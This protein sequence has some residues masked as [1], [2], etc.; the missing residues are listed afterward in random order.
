[1]RLRMLKMRVLRDSDGWREGW[2]G[3]FIGF[4]LNAPIGS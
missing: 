3:M 2:R 4:S 1:M